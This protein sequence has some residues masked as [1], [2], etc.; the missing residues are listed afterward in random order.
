VGPDRSSS[1][2]GSTGLHGAAF[3]GIR[4]IVVA[5]LAI[6]DG[7]SMLGYQSGAALAW[8]ASGGHGDVVGIL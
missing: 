5:L 1:P 3:L 8:R 7:M 2:K 6:R 4:E